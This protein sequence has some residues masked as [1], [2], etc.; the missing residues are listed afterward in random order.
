MHLGLIM[1]GNGR[2]ATKRSLPRAAGH[3]EGLKAAKRVVLSAIKLNIDYI[4][5]YVFSTENWK[6][7]DQEVNYLM[8]L[9]AKKLPGEMKL[10][11][12]NDIRILFRGDIDALP[13]DA[14]AGILKTVEETKDCK[15]LTVVL[16]VNYGGQD[17]IARACN[18]FIEKNPGKPISIKDIQDNLDL[19]EVPAPDMIARSAGELRLSNFM[20][21]DSAYAEFLAIDD[22]WPDWGE[23]QLQMCLDAL[24]HRV[25]KYGGLVK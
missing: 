14:R 8:N 25:R 10:Y 12:D 20:L 5:L 23:K 16:A 11:K 13:K 17:E 2:W 6:R 9:M 1:D 19:P 4:T 24:S 21:W 15:T 3:L 7:P 22:L 18:R